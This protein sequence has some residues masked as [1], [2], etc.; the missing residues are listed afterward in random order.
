[1]KDRFDRDSLYYKTILASDFQG[2]SFQQECQS[3]F[4]LKAT[5][6]VYA[7]P[8]SPLKIRHLQQFHFLVVKSRN[9]LFSSPL[10]PHRGLYDSFSSKVEMPMKPKSAYLK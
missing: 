6:A 10:S 4:M 5:V 9:G 2:H 3:L 1:M 8:S 7:E